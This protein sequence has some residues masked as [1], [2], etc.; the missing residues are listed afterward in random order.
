MSIQLNEWV[1]T[2]RE[3]KG[4]TQEQLGKILKVTKATISAW[5]NGRNKP[6]FEQV[7]LI[8]NI[9]EYSIPQSGYQISPIP[10]TTVNQSFP[11]KVRILM[12][13]YGGK[14]KFSQIINKSVTEIN[15]CLAET[16]ENN[17]LT[18]NLINDSLARAI[19]TRFNLPYNWL[20]Q[21]SVESKT[22]RSDNESAKEPCIQIKL[23][24]LDNYFSSN[25]LIKSER[26]KIQMIEVSEQWAYDHLGHNLQYIT[27]ITASGDSMRPT[28]GHNDLLFI[29]TSINFYNN[30]GIYVFVAQCGIRVKRLQMLLHNNVKII[31]DN[32]RYEPEILQKH[33]FDRLTI[34]GKVI[35]TWKFSQI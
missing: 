16:K 32:V 33:E 17:H 9:T 30:E 13:L 8:S 2:A 14:N 24:N 12:D 28:F 27:F 20:I 7:I 19:S 18:N 31:S 6:S 23:L 26:E 21:T 4:L 5:E 3:S 22:D 25:S 34:V 35:A 15:Q 11:E 10:I 29:D 1:K